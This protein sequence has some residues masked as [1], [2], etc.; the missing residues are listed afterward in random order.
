[1][2][3]IGL[4]AI[5]SSLVILF[6]YI[7]LGEDISGTYCIDRE[8]SSYRVD[9]E[10]SVCFGSRKLE[11]IYFTLD[12][13]TEDAFLESRSINIVGIN[14]DYYVFNLFI[15]FEGEDYQKF[16]ALYYGKYRINIGEIYY[17]S[18]VIVD[19][20][21]KYQFP[22]Y[23][24]KEHTKNFALG[25][26]FNFNFDYKIDFKTIPTDYDSSNSSY[27]YYFYEKNE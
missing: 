17:F 26:I 23:L 7:S 9:F 13:T 27:K 19:N 25:P 15:K 3:K 8:D 22:F 1:M 14:S 24:S 21:V 20:G 10:K 16:D 4:L 2:R 6:Q 18:S 12:R 5:I 11:D